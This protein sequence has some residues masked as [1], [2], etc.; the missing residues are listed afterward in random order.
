M[1][2]IWSP[3]MCGA[4]WADV[5]DR[6]FGWQTA[7][8]WWISGGLERPCA[9]GLRAG[10]PKTTHPRETIIRARIRVTTMPPPKFLRLFNSGAWRRHLSIPHCG[11]S[12]PEKLGFVAQPIDLP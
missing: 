7:L 11:D 2:T 6:P 4:R 12:E 3:Q 5:R 1:I 9:Y 10:A 8:F